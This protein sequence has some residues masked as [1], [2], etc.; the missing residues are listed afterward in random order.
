M[1]RDVYARIR[2]LE[3][4]HWWFTARREILSDQIARLG[5]PPAARVLEIGCGTG[6]NLEMLG[7][8]GSVVAIEPDAEARA[9]ASERW[10]VDV[11]AGTLPDGLP[12]F[13]TPF[14]L[15]AALDVIEH[16]DHDAASIASIGR[17]LKPGGHLVATVPANPWMWSAHDVSHH[18]KRR[19]RLGQFAALVNAGGLEVRKAS[20][21]NTLLFPAIS[22]VRLAKAAAGKDGGD[23]EAM[24]PAALNRVLHRLFA[25]ERA[26]LSA[27]DLPF[28]V[29]IL[30]IARRPA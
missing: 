6:G 8:F 5:L 21:F 17:L 30:L 9:Y 7:R 10:G 12:A 22:A 4:G 29:S 23:D 20:Y 1:E 11:A 3:Q 25:M 27:V 15:I 13:V 28:G 14:D 24:P 16:V 19:Y 26:L 2:E 18:H